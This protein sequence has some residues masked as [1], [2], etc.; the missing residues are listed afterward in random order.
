[1]SEKRW[2]VEVRRTHRR[3]LDQAKALAD[4]FADKYRDDLGLRGG[5]EGSTYPFAAKLSKGELEV[6]DAEIIVRV[7]LDFPLSMAKGKVR[8]EIEK[9]IDQE[10]SENF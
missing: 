9:E 4:A 8:K 1:M 2:Q 5:W 10:L 3:S 6:T 7:D